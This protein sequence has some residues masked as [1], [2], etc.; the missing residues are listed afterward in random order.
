MFSW[1]EESIRNS[2]GRTEIGSIGTT[3]FVSE[4]VCELLYLGSAVGYPGV[5]LCDIEMAG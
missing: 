4:E 1:A 3:V 5:L 2:M